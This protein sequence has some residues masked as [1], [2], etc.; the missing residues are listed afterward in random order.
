MLRAT[1][2]C[3]FS[4]SQLPKVVRSWCLLCILTWKCASR[5]N[6]VQF[7]ISHLASWLHLTKPF[8][9]CK[10]AKL[11]GLL[12]TI[13]LGQK[14]P[15]SL[16]EKSKSKAKVFQT[17]KNLTTTKQHYSYKNLSQPGNGKPKKD[18]LSLE[19]SYIHRLIYPGIYPLFFAFLNSSLDLSWDLS[20]AFWIPN[21]IFGFILGFIL[22]CLPS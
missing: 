10:S 2:A 1:T 19:P 12:V 18:I 22:Y 7:F 9:F 15:F 4:T 16:K 6:G 20:P 11:C 3:T 13:L 5:H 17:G 8:S 14:K 21:F